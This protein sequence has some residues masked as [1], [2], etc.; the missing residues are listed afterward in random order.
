MR[1][2]LILDYTAPRYRPDST[3]VANENFFR[4]FFKQ[5]PQFKQLRKK[6][7]DKEL[8]SFIKTFNEKLAQT[9]IDNRDGVYLPEQLG[10]IY[11][12]TIKR[13]KR[14]VNNKVSNEHGYD[15]AFPNHHSDGKLLKIA[16]SNRSSNFE[17]KDLWMFAA[18][19]DFKDKASKAFAQNYMRYYPLEDSRAIKSRKNAY[20]EKEGI[21]PPKTRKF[22]RKK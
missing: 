5:N 6:Y 17:N 14:T 15:I 18:S 7:S 9:A 3:T 22:K 11:L 2:K 12:A 13:P 8:K 16:Y 19:H 4:T 10:W 20:Y 1:K 21:A